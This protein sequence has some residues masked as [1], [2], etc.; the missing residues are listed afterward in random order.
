MKAQVNQAFIFIFM[1]II[2]ATITIISVMLF[3]KGASAACD[4][5]MTTFKTNLEK[6]VNSYSDYGTINVKKINVP[7]GHEKLYVLSTTKAKQEESDIYPFMINQMMDL[8]GEERDNNIFLEKE[9]E[10]TP[11]GLIKSLD[12]ETLAPVI[13]DRQG[14]VFKIKFLGK[15]KTTE[16][17]LPWR[18][19]QVLGCNLIGYSF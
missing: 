14:P 5:E 8:E 4:A 15:G 9:G 3:S 6:F 7:C 19:K 12:T 17:A 18:R 16:V 13:F 10:V 11:V 1:L 2:I